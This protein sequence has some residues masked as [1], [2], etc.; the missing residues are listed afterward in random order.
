MPSVNILT[1]SLTDRNILRNKIAPY[2]YVSLH[3]VK[4]KFTLDES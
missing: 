1:T 4:G 2:I 3:L